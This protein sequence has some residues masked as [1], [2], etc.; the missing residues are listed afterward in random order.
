MSTTQDHE[1][2]KANANP[3]GPMCHCCAEERE[4]G[5]SPLEP[6]NGSFSNGTQVD[7]KRSSSRSS[8]D[9]GHKSGSGGACENVASMAGRPPH[10]EDQQTMSNLL[11]EAKRT[12]LQRGIDYGHPYEDFSKIAQIWSVIFEQTVTPEQVGLAMIGVKVARITQNPNC[13]H[14]DSVLDIAGYSQCLDLV[15]NH[16]PFFPDED[17]ADDIFA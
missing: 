5:N 10:K 1:A 7:E 8:N 4:V 15:A 17:N 11:D 6:N 12:C 14:R 3:D 2:P 13:Y 9:C 16:N